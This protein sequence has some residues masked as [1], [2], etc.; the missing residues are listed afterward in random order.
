MRFIAIILVVGSASTVASVADAQYG[1]YGSSHFPQHGIPTGPV[2]QPPE[3]P[4]FVPTC[5]NC[6]HEVPR[7]SANGQRCPYCGVTWGG[8]GNSGSDDQDTMTVVVKRCLG[9]KAKVPEKSQ[10]GQ[11]CPKCG[12]KWVAGTGNSVKITIERVARKSS[13]QF[14]IWV[15]LGCLGGVLVLGGAGLGILKRR[16]MRRSPGDRVTTHRR[17]DLIPA[18]VGFEEPRESEPQAPR[19][20]VKLEWMYVIDGQEHGPV[21]AKELR[22]LAASGALTATDFVWREGMSNWAP[23][24]KLK[25]LF[26]S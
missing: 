22:R 26:S 5:M 13:S 15:V 19:T 10:D 8:K 17:S 1:P 20:A 6:R 21:T 3:M 7:G 12:V 9:C 18:L 25:G 2:F 16:S 14:I 24:S 23:A 11:K 4:R